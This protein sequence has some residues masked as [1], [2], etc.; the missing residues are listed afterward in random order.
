LTR[1]Y[2]FL[3]LCDVAE[4]FTNDKARNWLGSLYNNIDWTHFEAEDDTAALD[5]FGPALTF[6]RQQGSKREYPHSPVVHQQNSPPPRPA[7]RATRHHAGALFRKRVECTIPYAGRSHR[8]VYD[9]R[10]NNN[11]GPHHGHQENL[12]RLLFDQIQEQ[13][14]IK[15]MELE[16]CM[17]REPGA[18]LGLSRHARRRK[19]VQLRSQRI[20]AI[21]TA[22]DR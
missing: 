3:F 17:P 9:N 15:F 16:I 18:L 8:R 5:L 21:N 10:S 6:R 4:S 14:G 1:Y 12:I 2:F 13:M 20:T 19:Q 11:R 7:R 22:E